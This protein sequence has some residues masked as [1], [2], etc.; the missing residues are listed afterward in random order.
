MPYIYNQHENLVAATP[1]ADYKLKFGIDI[2]KKPDEQLPENLGPQDLV[3]HQ[4][5]KAV[6][7]GVGAG[8]SIASSIPGVK[9]VAGAISNSPIG[10]VGGVALDILSIPGKIVEHL[11]A[12][13]RLATSGGNMPDDI[14]S[15]LDRGADFNEIAN[16]MVNT[17]R[18]FS[19]DQMANLAFQILLDPLNLTPAVLGKVRLLKPLSTVGGALTGATVGGMLGPVGGIVGGGIGAFAA[20]RK[21][22]KI[23]EVASEERNIAA[24]VKRGDDVAALAIPQITDGLK[25][26]DLVSK[27]NR[28]VGVDF[29]N[30]ARNTKSL[31]TNLLAAQLEIDRAE[32]AVE[33]G[34]AGA[35]AALLDARTKLATASGAIAKSAEEGA[36]LGGF[37]MGVYDTIIGSKNMATTPL[38]ALAA[39]FQRPASQALLATFGEGGK[40]IN[41]VLNAFEKYGGKEIVD[42]FQIALGHGMNRSLVIAAERVLTSSMEKQV[43]QIAQ[44]TNSAIIK[45]KESLAIQKSLTGAEQNRQVNAIV[46]HMLNSVEGGDAAFI[47]G[48]SNREVLAERVKVTFRMEGVASSSKAVDVLKEHI[49]VEQTVTRAQ[50]LATQEGG[51]AAEYAR[52]IQAAEKNGDASF[53][54]QSAIQSEFESTIGENIQHVETKQQAERKFKEFFDSF[55]VDLQMDPADLNKMRSEIFEEIF[56]GYYEKDAYGISRIK[57]KGLGMGKDDIRSLA[58]RDLSMFEMTGYGKANTEL[59]NIQSSVAAKLAEVEKEIQGGRLYGE[60]MQGL[61]EVATVLREIASSPLTLVRKGSSTQQGL[62]LYVGIQKI[63]QDRIA[64]LPYDASITTEL[65]AERLSA[66]VEESVNNGIRLSPEDIKQINKLIRIIKGS[67]TI[68][69]GELNREFVASARARFDDIHAAFPG[70]PGP[71]GSNQV[72]G[73]AGEVA[74]V[75]KTMLNEGVSLSPLSVS[76]QTSLSQTLHLIMGPAFSRRLEAI[77]SNGYLLAKAPK[78]N[79]ISRIRRYIDPQTGERFYARHIMPFVDMTSPYI[80]NLM[81]KPDRYTANWFQH[82][83]ATLF[84]PIAQNRLTASVYRRMASYLAK[85]GASEEEVGR[86]MDSLIQKSVDRKLNARGLGTKDINEAFADAFGQTS[87]GRFEAFKYMWSQVSKDPFA[88]EKAVMYA[89][90]GDANLVGATQYFTGG[91]KVAIPQIAMLTDRFWP[92]VKYSANPMFWTQ[93]FVESPTLNAVNGVNSSV[94]SSILEDGRKLSIDYKDVQR[95]AG[96]GPDTKMLIDHVS[97]TAIFREKAFQVAIGSDATRISRL[98]QFMQSSKWEWL[99]DMKK[100]KRDIMASEFASRNF[101]KELQA[102]DPG[103]YAVLVDHY[104]TTNPRSLFIQYLTDRK[105]QIKTAGRLNNF[106]SRRPIGFAWAVIPDKDGSELDTILNKMGL[107]RSIEEMM[108]GELTYDSAARLSDRL[109]EMTVAL[110]HAGYN[111]ANFSED[112]EGIRRAAYSAGRLKIKA[113]IGAE[114]GVL[115]KFD[116]SAPILEVENLNE[117]TARLRNT[118]IKISNLRVRALTAKEMITSLFEEITGQPASFDQLRISEA[119]AMGHTYGEH[120]TKLNVKVDDAIRRAIRQLEDEIGPVPA[121]ALDADGNVIE[122]AR[123]VS[124][125]IDMAEVKRIA[126]SELLNDSGRVAFM[127]ELRNANYQLLTKHGGQEKIFRTFEYVYG[128]AVE[129]A[130]KVHYFNPDRSFFER[131]I[132]HPVLGIYPYSYMMHKVLPE[133]VKLLFTK[134]FGMHAPGAGYAAYADIRNYITRE[135]ESNSELRRKLAASPDVVNLISALFPGLPNDISISF[136]R[137]VR[138]PVKGFIT[139]TGYGKSGYGIANLSTDMMGAATG[140]GVAGLVGSGSRAIEQLLNALGPDAPINIQSDRILGE[141]QLTDL[142]R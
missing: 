76:T 120:I 114:S 128:K 141:S 38:R 139:Q 78:T 22:S 11:G 1:E 94:I 142:T 15:M 123:L 113:R 118:F 53:N 129:E 52:Y 79:I 138:N 8:V 56:G 3:A 92:A 104:G 125:E 84:A 42:K 136:S 71:F 45:A 111:I 9:E 85:A 30:K 24:A 5:G 133:M 44:E 74:M 61:E 80:D 40:R 14:K 20:R 43:A 28:E 101:V 131:S 102:R 21:I 27:L 110:Q 121:Q 109:D 135:I 88:A 10:A 70:D 117:A 119:I 127:R 89:F 34:Q 17:G 106:E 140:V 83:Y 126:F 115:T 108:L 132:N 7:T 55:S 23:I 91:V 116:E 47:Y 69:V 37:S 19:N 86:I 33:A 57:S 130:N 90:R 26:T 49:R 39:A 54:A 4:F 50:R 36:Y 68:G 72:Y 112:I 137:F 60:D 65:L 124:P 41:T 99:S 16:Y 32:K 93:E 122:N 98:Q 12:R 73:D 103:A 64:N 75:M 96:V 63:I 18:G 29:L 105:M 77:T 6:A 62:E 58:A 95:L 31:S 66:F 25:Y 87:K 46:D 107:D 48:T 82:Q 97:Y 134:P 51:A 81:Q 2:G 67:E 59:A 13:A 100:E 35:D